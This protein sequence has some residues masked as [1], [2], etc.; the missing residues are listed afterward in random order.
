MYYARRHH[1]HILLS[2]GNPRCETSLED[3]FTGWRRHLF[4]LRGGVLLLFPT[5]NLS[6]SP[7]PPFPPS[8]CRIAQNTPTPHEKEAKQTNKQTTNHHHHHQITIKSHD[9]YV[10]ARIEPRRRRRLVFLFWLLTGIRRRF[11]R[12]WRRRRRSRVFPR[13]RI[14]RTFIPLFSHFK[15]R[16]VNEATGVH[17]VWFNTVSHFGGGEQF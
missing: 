11:L 14:V 9:I 10:L 5:T 17:S 6:L 4:H 13:R 1:L 16:R 12:S 2:S 3:A 8:S 7:P 15:K